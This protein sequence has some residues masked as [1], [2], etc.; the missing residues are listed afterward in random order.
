MPHAFDTKYTLV[1]NERQRQVI[2]Q[3]L[4]CFISEGFDQ[5]GDGEYGENT[6][7]SLHDM[8]DLEGTAGP[9]SPVP[10]INGLVL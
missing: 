6:A 3:A 5:S 8:V 1:I 4:S 7:R 9:L 10:A 2:M